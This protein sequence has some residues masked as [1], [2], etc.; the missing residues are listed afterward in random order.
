MHVTKQDVQK[1]LHSTEPSHLPHCRGRAAVA[2]VISGRSNPMLTL[3]IKASH[4]RKHAG[5][6][7]LPGGKL[8]DDDRSAVVAALRELYEETGLQLGR[9]NALGYLSP[10]KSLYE[11]SVIP[12][13]FWSDTFLQGSP[14]EQEIAEV[15]TIPLTEFVEQTPRFELSRH[16]SPERLMPRWR[17]H[18]VN[19]WGLTALIVNDFFETVFNAQFGESLPSKL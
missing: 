6:V 9:H 16:R 10:I 1:K 13:V 2:F 17:Y 15:F 11:L 18:N 7:S 14:Q 12:C 4:L 19:I 5:E 8:E 3:C